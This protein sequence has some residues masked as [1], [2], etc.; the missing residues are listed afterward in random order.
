MRK[1]IA[2]V[3]IFCLLALLCAPHPA[4]AQDGGG[5]SRAAEPASQPSEDL[6]AG[7]LPYDDP[8]PLGT[9]GFFGAIVRTIFSLA[10]VLGLLYVTLWAIRRFTG[11]AAGPSAGGMVRVVGR[12]YL[13][14]KIVVYFLRLADEL[15][16][17]GTNAGDI[18]LLTSITDEHTINRIEN[19]LRSAQGGVAKPGFSRLF[20]RSMSRFQKTPEKDDS[21]FDDQL[22]MLN[23]QIGRLKGLARRK[24]SDEE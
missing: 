1:A 19:D 4:I 11:G 24:Q 20:D 17:I 13:S 3:A 7:Y 12:I 8:T 6:G 5:K 2:A 15:L 16:V 18:S 21:I 23:E 10:F 14:P 22:S 9:G